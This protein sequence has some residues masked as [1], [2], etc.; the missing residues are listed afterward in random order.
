MIIKPKSNRTKGII[1]S[2]FMVFALI[3]QPMYGLVAS[4]VAKA[5]SRDVC[6]SECNY[7]T[8]QGAIDAAIAGDLA[9]L[10]DQLAG[11]HVAPRDRGDQ[12]IAIARDCGLKRLVGADVDRSGRPPLALA[13]M[14]WDRE[15]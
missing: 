4:Q 2:S 1:A 15:R 5:A 8:I 9:H 14:A 11:V 6:A 3:A 13:A 10:R 12:R 7:T